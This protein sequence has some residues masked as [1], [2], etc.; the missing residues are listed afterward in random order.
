MNCQTAY[1]EIATAFCQIWVIV[2]HTNVRCCFFCHGLHFSY[3]FPWQLYTAPLKRDYVLTKAFQIPALKMN[4][5]SF[6]LSLYAKI[7]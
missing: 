5:I 1:I 7:K 6:L 4:I 2:Y 3:L